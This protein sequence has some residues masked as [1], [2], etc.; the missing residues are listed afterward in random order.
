MIAVWFGLLQSSV[1]RGL[2]RLCGRGEDALR[3]M[4]AAACTALGLLAALPASAA[5]SFKVLPIPLK[6]V[7]LRPTVTVRIDGKD[8]NFLIDSGSAVNFISNRLT[9]G[10][11]AISPQDMSGAAGKKIS[12]GRIVVSRVEFLGAGFKD[13][14]FSVSDKLGEA[15]G[16]LGQPMLRRMDVEY[17]LHGG[18]IRLVK[19]ED[20]KGAEMVYWLKTGQAYSKIPM[21]WTDPNDTHTYGT[22]FINGQ[23]MR[24]GFDTGSPITFITKAAAA[25][26]GVPVTGPGVTSIGKGRGL[27]SD[28]DAW[29]ANFADVKIGDEEI[30]NASLEIGQ[31]ATDD[32]DILIGADFF[33]SH[34]VY[35]SHIQGKIY[36]AYEGG[37]VFQ[38]QQ[39]R[40]SAA[41]S[42][43]TG[44]AKAPD[45]IAQR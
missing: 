2:K 31:S 41:T 3:F 23:K 21:A 45:P 39:L 27:D 12:V 5:C 16:M 15:D 43:Q 36:F 32:F 17:D 24:A 40:P 38:G 4:I 34:H 37:P 7:G 33:V 28:F 26:A 30:K 13:Q 18:V 11:L 9:A 8:L 25:R 19:T 6:M 29:V 1:V 20:C 44:A 10:H 22:V 42:P 35:V 14:L